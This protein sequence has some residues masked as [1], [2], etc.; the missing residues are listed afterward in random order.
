MERSEGR[1]EEKGFR[2]RVFYKS[3]TGREIVEVG[4]REHTNFRG[5]RDQATIHKFSL[6]K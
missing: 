5:D 4:T 1:K 3:E 2:E 6:T